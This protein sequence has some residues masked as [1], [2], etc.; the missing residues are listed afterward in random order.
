VAEAKGLARLDE[1]GDIDVGTE[2]VDIRKTPK[3]GHTQGG[4]GRARQGT[5]DRSDSPWPLS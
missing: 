1:A 4:A 3:A 2:E 5:S